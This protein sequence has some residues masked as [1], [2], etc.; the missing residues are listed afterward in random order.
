MNDY[1]LMHYISNY[2]TSI[3]LTEHCVISADIC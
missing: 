3:V 1:K 2:S